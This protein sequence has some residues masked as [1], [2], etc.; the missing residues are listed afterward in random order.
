MFSL[1]GLAFIFIVGTGV[2]A[3]RE[4]EYGYWNLTIV[5]GASATGWRYQDTTSVFFGRGDQEGGGRGEVQ[6]HWVYNPETRG[7]T[8]ECTEGGFGYQWGDEGRTDI[9]VQQT[10]ENI[11]GEVGSITLGGTANVTLRYGTSANGRGFEGRVIVS[12]KRCCLGRMNG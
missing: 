6:C 12:A 2:G 5:G 1:F 3:V 4:K 9:T 11:D 10:L 8:M 7:E